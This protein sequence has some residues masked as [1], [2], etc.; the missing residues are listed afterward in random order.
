MRSPQIQ[1]RQQLYFDQ[2]RYAVCISNWLF[3][4]LDRLEPSAIADSWERLKQI[5]W[6]MKPD[7][8]MN[9]ELTPV[10]ELADAI[11]DVEQ[12]WTGFKCVNSWQSR[13][14]YT[15][16]LAMAQALQ[17]VPDCRLQ[18]FR[19]AQPCLP[20]DVVQLKNSQHSY[21]SWLRERRVSVEQAQHF[22]N[23][24]TQRGDH[25]RVNPDTRRRLYSM[26]T[27]PQSRIR[28]PF[29]RHSYID[30]HSDQDLTMIELVLPG[31]IRKTLPIQTK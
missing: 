4:Y 7:Q 24:L 13:Y 22:W 27:N 12:R 19:E 21:R 15:N 8:I 2:Y 28:Y 1:Q 14:Y 20:R 30:H 26:A 31:F 23:F 25:Y 5:G 18:Y 9:T 10:L 17:A 16:D 11:R 6:W 3:R 29:G